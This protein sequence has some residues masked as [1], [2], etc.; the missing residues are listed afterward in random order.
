MEKQLPYQTGHVILTPAYRCAQDQGRR[1]DAHNFVVAIKN[2]IIQ[3]TV[4]RGCLTLFTGTEEIR[5]EKHLTSAALIGQIAHLPENDP[6]RQGTPASNLSG[7]SFIVIWRGS[8]RSMACKT[9]I[10]VLTPDI[11]LLAVYMALFRWTYGRIYC[12]A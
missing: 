11:A 5:H 1:A 6:K 7:S 4:H 12:L 9:P 10:D 3:K 2:L 8:H